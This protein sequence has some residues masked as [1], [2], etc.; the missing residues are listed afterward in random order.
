MTKQNVSSQTAIQARSSSTLSTPHTTL[1]LID[2][3][4]LPEKPCRCITQTS[5]M[6]LL[7][8]SILSS[9][10]PW[11][12][13]GG[14]GSGGDSGDMRVFRTNN[15]CLKYVAQYYNKVVW[16]QNMLIIFMLFVIFWLCSVSGGQRILAVACGRWLSM[17]LSTQHNAWPW[18]LYHIR[19]CR[20]MVY[21]MLQK[22]LEKCLK[23]Q[24]T[25]SA[26]FK[27]KHILTVST[28]IPV[29]DKQT[30]LK[31]T[32]IAWAKKRKIMRKKVMILWGISTVY[33]IVH[34]RENCVKITGEENRTMSNQVSQTLRHRFYF[35]S[36]R[37]TACSKSDFHSS[38]L[39]CLPIRQA[40][41]FCTQQ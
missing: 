35:H 10:F 32:Q 8:K 39:H 37:F 13:V 33:V 26:I 6:Y 14:G 21:F 7:F 23:M 18:R 15:F 5:K 30:I 11:G 12:Q 1:Y 16:H 25:V 34:G 29:H 22:R 3:I 41:P 9:T 24:A 17:L 2:I 19:R 40:Q 36:L 27:E 31:K 38:T 4:T 20:N 28:T